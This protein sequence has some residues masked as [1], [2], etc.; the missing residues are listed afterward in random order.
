[1]NSQSPQEAFYAILS[2]CLDKDNAVRK[3]AE[4]QIT[5]ISLTNYEDILINCSAFL[6]NDNFQNDIR[7]LCAV[8]I[9][10]S[11]AGE[12]NIKRWLTI[13]D[14]KKNV[15]K[16]NVLACLGSE[17]KEIRRGA[18]TAVAALAKIELQRGTWS[19]LIPTLY[20]ASQHQNINYKLSSMITAGYI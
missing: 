10:N 12:D 17:K 1:M 11:V 15:I 16:S 2:K 20:S 4:E 19:T 8:I 13:P 5:S 6:M 7:Q 18:A 3:A 14:D 9:K